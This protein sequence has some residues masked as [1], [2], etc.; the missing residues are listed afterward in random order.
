MSGLWQQCLDTNTG[1]P[2]YWNTAS[3]QVSWDCPPEF[4]L[5]PPQLVTNISLATPSNPV[6]STSTSSAST[7]S[8]TTSNTVNPTL[9]SLVS[10]YDSED[11]DDDE[12]GDKES[13]VPGGSEAK[14]DFIGPVIPKQTEKEKD[15]KRNVGEADDILSLIEA[16]KPPDYADSKA[17]LPSCKTNSRE[18]K[19]SVQAT[20]MLALANYDDSDEETEA[21][22]RPSVSVESGT[23][24]DQY[25]RL[26]F[27]PASQAEPEWQTAEQREALLRYR[28]EEQ[29]SLR[30]DRPSSGETEADGGSSVRRF[31]NSRPGSR[32]RRLDLPKGKFNKTENLENLE[33]ET[34]K[35]AVNFVPFVKSSSVLPGTIESHPTN[36]GVEKVEES[37]ATETEQSAGNS[38]ELVNFEQY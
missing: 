5:P 9:S 37:A 14:D 17:K 16:E 3:N 18:T 30:A 2:Y 10:G 36:N 29:R 38:S 6:T 23:R 7:T 20:S 33:T 35:Q 15:S 19:E 22:A 34:E 31:D 25:G 28:L 27:N 1:Q 11:S 26:V 8:N 24:L 32:K 21:E 4:S 13:Q 12:N